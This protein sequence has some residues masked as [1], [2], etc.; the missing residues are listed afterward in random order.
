MKIT[1]LAS[2]AAGVLLTA[3]GAQADDSW[4]NTRMTYAT[5][6]QPLFNANEFSLD[7]FGAYQANERHFLA[8][9]NTSIHHGNWGGGVGGNYFFTPMLGVGVETTF[10]SGTRHFDDHIN[11]NFIFRIPIEVAHIAPYVLAGGGRSFNP[12]WYWF[13]DAGVGL[14]FRL[15]PKMGIF[16]DARY[17]WESTSKAPDQAALRAGIK[18]VF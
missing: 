13:G 6:N 12:G 7:L 2:L 9:P 8:W 18:V 11:G 16:T 1:K 5:D 17:I 3:A 15:N 4:F 14:E 10:L